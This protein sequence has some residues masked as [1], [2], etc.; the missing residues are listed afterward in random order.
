MIYLRS[1][2]FYL[3]WFPW[4]LGATLLC[5]LSIPLPP[6]VPTNIGRAWAYVTTLLLRAVCGLRMEIRGRENIP[7]G[8]CLIACKHQSA[9]ETA[10]FLHVL[11]WGLYTPKIEL[12]RFPLFGWCLSRI[13]HIGIDRKAGA[14]ALRDLVDQTRDRLALG[15][16]VVIFP[17]GRRVAVDATE[18]Y[19]PGVAAIYA[20]ADAVVVPAA[21]NSGFFWARNS[22]LKKPG[23]V[24]LEFLEPIQPGMDRREFLRH[25][26]ESIETRSRALLEEARLAEASRTT[27]DV[28]IA[29][30]TR[31]AGPAR[32]DADGT[33]KR[34][35]IG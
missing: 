20:K 12:L 25:I 30:A 16:Q 2:L 8:A 22:F 14:R 15:R 23:T 28:P 5:T 13:G 3:L 6:R 32:E 35:G 31:R 19:H 24:V 7:E 33:Q 29:A 18:K 26:E 34:E 4:T 9:W 21:L 1:L 11:D 10:V 17:E 27:A